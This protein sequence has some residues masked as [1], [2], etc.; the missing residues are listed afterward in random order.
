M[1]LTETLSQRIV[2]TAHQYLGRPYDWK[3]FDCIHFI[4]SVYKECGIEV[5]RFGGAGYPPEN[6]HL[7]A[8][9]FEIM[10]LGHS[11][12]FKR[13]ANLKDRI[14]THA[15]IIVSPHELVHCSRHFGECV[16]ITPKPE[17]LEIYALAPKA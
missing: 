3:T 1:I 2:A 10:P 7:S 6:F 13:K 9:T 12:F 5:P 16:T 8:E 14:W 17:F 4:L 15:A 11:V